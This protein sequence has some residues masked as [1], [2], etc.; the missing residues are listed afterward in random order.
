ME[1]SKILFCS[2]KLPRARERISSKSTG[3]LGTRLQKRI[4]DPGIGWQFVPDSSRF[5]HH[6]DPDESAFDQK[7][8][9]PS[10]TCGLT[11]SISR[12]GDMS[13]PHSSGLVMGNRPHGRPETG[14]RRAN[15]SLSAGA[16]NETPRMTNDG[17]LELL[18]QVASLWPWLALKPQRHAAL[19]FGISTHR[20]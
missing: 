6:L 19:R 18:G 16:A 3:N 17:G 11:W 13:P 15:E 12:P 5:R 20:H 8:R 7:W 2:A 10:P 1:G 9:H 4:A 14:R